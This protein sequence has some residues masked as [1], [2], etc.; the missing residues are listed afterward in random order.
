VKYAAKVETFDSSKQS[1][2]KSLT[3][4]SK[5]SK[6]KLAANMPDQPDVPVENDKIA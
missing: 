6:A 5:E 3:L 4:N 1:T 2:T